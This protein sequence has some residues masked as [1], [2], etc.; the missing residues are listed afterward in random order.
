M[1]KLI[2]FGTPPQG[3]ESQ[4]LWLTAQYLLA[5]VVLRG[6]SNNDKL[7]LVEPI[8]EFASIVSEQAAYIGVQVTILTTCFKA[9]PASDS[10]WLRVHPSLLKRTVTRLA[11]NGL[12]VFVDM[13]TDTNIESGGGG[14]AFE[15]PTQC[16]KDNLDSLLGGSA[17]NPGSS[18]LVE[19]HDHFTSAVARAISVFVE[20]ANLDRNFHTISI[21]NFSEAVNQFE[22]CTIVDWTANSNISVQVQPVDSQVSFQG[23]K[24]YWLVGLTGSLGLSLC[25]WMTQRGARYFVLSSRK[26]DIQTAWVDEMRAKGVHVKVSAWSVPLLL[27]HDKLFPISFFMRLC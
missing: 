1:R 25:E 10:N 13:R 7:L 26:A 12:S 21:S 2:S 24:T 14:F 27:M 8:I 17:C 4:L 20:T 15:L 23:N 18:H 22:P 11:S 6:L 3:S 5:S 19:I 9:S 16:R